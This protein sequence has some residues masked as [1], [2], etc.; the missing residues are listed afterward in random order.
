[1]RITSPLAAVK[2]QNLGNPIAHILDG[3]CCA[4]VAH[5]VHTVPFANFHNIA[6]LAAQ[7]DSRA[8]GLAGVVSRLLCDVDVDLAWE[9]GAV[10]GEGMCEGGRW[11]DE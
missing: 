3:E 5:D 1:M 7:L 4:C 2:E 10:R 8:V 9:L 6:V 11:R